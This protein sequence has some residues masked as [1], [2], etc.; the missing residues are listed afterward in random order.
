MD[1][2]TSRIHSLIF[3]KSRKMHQKGDKSDICR[4]IFGVFLHLHFSNYRQNNTHFVRIYE[5]PLTKSFN[6][7]KTQS[8]HTKHTHRMISFIFIIQ[9]QT[10]KCLLKSILRNQLFDHFSIILLLSI[11]KLAICCI[12]TFC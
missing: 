2:I 1:G 4:P 10:D 9:P 3:H 5:Q 8:T 11:F 7:I 12:S 6:I